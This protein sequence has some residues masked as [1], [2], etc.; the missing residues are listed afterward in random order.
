MARKRTHDDAPRSKTV[1]V[2]MREAT[3][4]RVTAAAAEAGL[5]RA[6]YVE[7]VLEGRP[8]PAA[9][10]AN[11][12]LPVAL[13][14]ELKRLGNNLNQIA[15]NTHCD[16]APSDRA[17]ACVVAEVFQAL[18]EHEI[19]RRRLGEVSGSTADA[20]ADQVVKDLWDRIART[21][22]HR[23]V[24]PAPAPKAT[25][26]LK[27]MAST[28][29]QSTEPA[30]TGPAPVDTPPA[31]KPLNAACEL[32]TARHPMDFGPLPTV[33]PYTPPRPLREIRI[34]AGVPMEFQSV[35]GEWEA[36]DPSH[37]VVRAARALWH[38]VSPP[39]E[40]KST[41]T[42]GVAENGNL[43]ITRRPKPPGADNGP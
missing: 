11:T 15:H 34:P 31:V 24:M 2:R 26:A 1:S 20:K 42:Y 33:Q 4:A 5:S 36:R 37:P 23:P 25:H 38:K 29:A 18:A 19:M 8:L 39:A 22:P 40:P 6:G 12:A 30:P 3:F 27:P 32:P 35:D 13:I 9:Q 16:I 41:T 10:P 14:N 28:R 21:L 43:V 17:I 7:H